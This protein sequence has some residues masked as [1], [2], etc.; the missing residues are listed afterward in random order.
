MTRAYDVVVIGSGIGGMCAAARLARAGHRTL[1]VEKLPR[2]GGRCST[3]DYKG[4]KLTTGAILVN[5]GDVLEQTFVDVD[6]EFPVRRSPSRAIYRIR[7]RDYDLPA[8][9]GLRA[10]AEIAAQDQ[11]A[12]ERLW[13]P[14]RRALRGEE[15]PPAIS[16]RSWI[17]GYTDNQGIQDLFQVIIAAFMG[18]NS[19]EALAPDY[20]DYLKVMAGAVA[21]G[22]APH[23]SRSLVES[24]AR[25]V[26]RDGGEIWTE[27]RA[28][29]IV[30]EDGLARGVVV[31]RK[32][33]PVTIEAK[34]VV[35]DAGPKRTVELA[36]AEHF[37]DKYLQLIEKRLLPAGCIVTFTASDQPLM[38]TA[39]PLM[40][41]GTRRVCLLC[42]PT[43]VC[44]ELAPPGKHLLEAIGTLGASHGPVD[45]NQEIE[46]HL[47][48]LRDTIPGYGEKG[49]LL[50]VSSY[51]DDW[52]EYRSWPG[53][54]LP[55][56]TPIPN[57]YNVGDGVKP[58]GWP[59]LSASAESARLVVEELHA[60]GT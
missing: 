58:D 12:T 13:Q 19:D 32:G 4:Y 57:L 11:E 20:F 31:E 41:T 3:I 34:T 30:V 43:L 48:D 7:G 49:E 8:K 1:V 60:S 46:L 16:V 37:D 27:T 40:P 52:P 50:M 2:L 22:Y 5:C 36:G 47:Q 42:T 59:G 14:M 56:K 6:A 15:R 51:R 26:R 23:G 17:A 39:G 55:Q 53:R 44:P 54:D 35:S 25:A 10:L 24:L 21:H 38:E 45:M 28:T 9:G 33:Q 29:Q 18:I